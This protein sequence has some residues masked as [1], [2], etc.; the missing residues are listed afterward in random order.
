MLIYSF[1]K[2]PDFF[3]SQPHDAFWVA[4]YISLEC[5]VQSLQAEEQHQIINTAPNLTCTLFY[6]KNMKKL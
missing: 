6:Y 4:N 3:T 1:F 5:D 2:E